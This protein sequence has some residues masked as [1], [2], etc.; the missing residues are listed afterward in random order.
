MP[1]LENSQQYTE[2]KCLD[3]LVSV[4]FPRGFTPAGIPLNIARI[5]QDIKFLYASP[6][7]RN[8]ALPPPPNRRPHSITKVAMT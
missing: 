2:N 6:R 8:A 7:R 3:A 5:Y 4:F 1:L